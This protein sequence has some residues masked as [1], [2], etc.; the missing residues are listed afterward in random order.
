MARELERL[1]RRQAG[2]EVHW[3]DRAERTA[4]RSDDVPA[5]VSV[6]GVSVPRGAALTLDR[7]TTAD[8][9]H[10]LGATWRA[11]WS[12]RKPLLARA[13][14]LPARVALLDMCVG[15]VLPS[16]AGS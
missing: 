16:G 12:R 7:R 8:L 9:R 14:P 4:N 2:L 5:T 10:R 6:G 1:L 13:A 15:S 3:A 11:F